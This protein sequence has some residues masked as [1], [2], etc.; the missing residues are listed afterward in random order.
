MCRKQPK[1]PDCVSSRSSCAI[2]S[3]GSPTTARPDAIS[4]STA[5]STEPAGASGSAAT[6]W[7]Y[8]SQSWRPKRTFSRALALVSAMCIGP[9]SRHAERCATW[10]KSVARSEQIFQL[11]ASALKPPVVVAPIESRPRPC[12]PAARAPAGDICDATHISMWGR[13]YGASWRRASRS[14][15]QSLL[16]VTVSP[17][18]SGA[19]TPIASS[20]MSR[21]FSTSMPIMKAS[22]GSAPGPMPKIARPRVMWS[23][24]LMRSA[25]ISG[26]W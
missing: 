11:S 15:N 14:S 3:S 20:I 8:L 7:K 6:S 12:L 1:P 4:A 21:C 2:A 10:P 16:C 18:S 19:S 17:R 25:S 26:W 13:V 9:T 24:W 23:S 22:L 5:L